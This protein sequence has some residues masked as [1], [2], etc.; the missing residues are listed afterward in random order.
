MRSVFDQNVVMRRIPVVDRRG[1]GAALIVI[2]RVVH[3]T[4]FSGLSTACFY[5]RVTMKA[6]PVTPCT[7]VK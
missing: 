5:G 2:V 6:L 7:D 1:V 3:G 4:Y